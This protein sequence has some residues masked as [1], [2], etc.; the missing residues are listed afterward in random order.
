M[1]RLE[2]DSIELVTLL[3]YL[4][5]II[6]SINNNTKTINNNNNNNNS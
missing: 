6:N 2:E 3:K 5:V 1:L 4:G